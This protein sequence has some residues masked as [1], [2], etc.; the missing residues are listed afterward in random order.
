MSSLAGVEIIPSMRNCT[1]C[2]GMLWQRKASDCPF[3]GFTSD[4][5]CSFEI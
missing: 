1:A 5:T 3:L 2:Y 4:R